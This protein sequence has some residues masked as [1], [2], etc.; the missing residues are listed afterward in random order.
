[1]LVGL[2]AP[3]TGP[4]L[5]FTTELLSAYIWTG[6]ALVLA[7]ALLSRAGWFSLSLLAPLVLSAGAWTL[8][9]GVPAPDILTLPVPTGVPFGELRASLASLYWPEVSLSWREASQASP[10]N[11]WKPTFVM[12][13]SLATIVLS[14]AAGAKR[15]AWTTALAMAAFVG[16]LGLLSEEVA[17]AVLMLWVGLEFLDS[18]PLQKLAASPMRLALASQRQASSSEHSHPESQDKHSS[19]SHIARSHLS[20][21]TRRSAFM[22]SKEAGSRAI[23]PALAATLLAIGGG[24]VSAFLTG[25]ATSGMSLVWHHDPASR[26]PLGTLL[27]ILPGGVGSL[28]LG[29]VPVAAVALLLA[30]RHRLV[31]ALVVGSATLLLLGLTLNYP[32]SPHDVLRFDGHARNFALLALLVALGI[33]ISDL[34]NRLR[35]AAGAVILL[36]VAWP[37]SVEPVRTLALAVAHGIELT[38]AKPDLNE[39]GGQPRSDPSFLKIGRY[40]M[41]S[42]VSDRVRDYIRS[43]TPVDARILSP[44]WDL[45]SAST[46]RPN[47]AGF[48]RFSHLTPEA[49][50]DYIDAISFLEPVAL[51]RMGTTHVHVTDSWLSGMSARAR[52]WLYDPEFFELLVRGHTDSLYRV[53]PAFLQLN[54]APASRSFEALRLTIPASATVRVIGLTDADAARTAATLAH[55]RLQ[56]SFPRGDIHLR[57]E[58]ASQPPH[59]APAD[60]VVIPRDR[61]S[62]F[63]LRKVPPIWWNESVIAYAARASVSPVVDPPPQPEAQFT[64]RLSE[65]QQTN[66]QIDFRATFTDHAPTA[67][68][69]QDWLLISGRDLPWALP[70]EDNGIAV[71]SLAWFAGQIVPGGETTHVYKYDARQNRLAVRNPDGSFAAIPSS[72]DRL[73]PGL[74]ILAVRLRSDHLQAAIIPVMRIAVMESGASVHTLYAGEHATQIAPCPE[75]LKYT[76]SCRRIALES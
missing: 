4:N 9:I 64:V 55:A 58:I 7:T 32:P 6:F 53:L 49:G 57:S 23:G 18:I 43:Q 31:L 33:R 60:F 44:E 48:V 38:N 66:N 46:G 73:T 69:G 56:G 1:M 72:G 11:I 35:Y 5:A 22:L 27:T 10:P 76:R 59:S 14:Y 71:A 24:P 74:Y 47:A 20:N 36:L 16:F 26:L 12:A 61:P 8:L 29:V 19:G 3:P 52:R 28:G 42:P 67:W 30:G 39:S 68:T 15:R 40:A 41:L 54:P 17:L 2:L 62:P 37:T 13:Y 50:P 45:I 34:S 51:R 25:E 75:R 63:G 70:T 21:G 65:I